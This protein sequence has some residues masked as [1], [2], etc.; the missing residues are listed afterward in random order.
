MEKCLVTKLKTVVDNTDLLKL[1]EC[2]LECHARK[3]STNAY[4]LSISFQGVNEPV[5]L[6][7]EG[8]GTFLSAST[9][10]ATISEDGKSAV[11]T[12]QG[13]N[14][15]DK[16]I[17]H[18][19]DLEGTII[20][21]NKYD[22]Y[23]F[24]ARYGIV[25]NLDD[26]KYMIKLRYI[27]ANFPNKLLGDL[28]SLKRCTCLEDMQ[29]RGEGLVNTATGSITDLFNSW[30]GVRDIS[31]YPSCKI[32]P[33]GKMTYFNGSEI[34]TPDRGTTFFV[35]FE[36]GGYKMYQGEDTTGELV[37]NYHI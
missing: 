26:L 9:R 31:K 35:Q 14:M 25:C 23:R 37:Y 12:P 5:T 4:E 36:E 3:A 33:N 16:R 24:L 20:A 13:E 30:V 32:I 7:I 8:A 21:D 17:F 28:S 11:I 22:V 29:L 19:Y 1:G 27:G 2:K 6:K 10:Y 18:S 34:V 15:G